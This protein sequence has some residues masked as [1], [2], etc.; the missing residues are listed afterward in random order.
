MIRFLAA[1]VVLALAAPAALADP[2][3]VDP[4]VA[5]GAS[6]TQLS[7]LAYPDPDVLPTAGGFRLFGT[8]A[9]IP[10]TQINADGSRGTRAPS[11]KTPKWAAAKPETW[12][13]DVWQT[14][15]PL[16]TY[17]MYFTAMDAA[18]HRHCLGVATAGAPQGPYTVT[19]RK[20]AT[21]CPR[22]SQH[23]AI[24]PTMVFDGTQRWMVFK[25]NVGNASDF[26]IQALP[27]NPSGVSRVKNATPAVLQGLPDERMENPAL[28]YH[29]GTWW[30]FL[31]RDDYT[32]CAYYTDAR[33]ATS[34]L[35]PYGAPKKITGAK[36]TGAAKA[37]G[38]CGAGGASLD[39][40]GASTR[41]TLHAF[42]D[43]AHACK[44]CRRYPWT[45]F[46][47]WNKNDKPFI[48]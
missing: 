11:L 24:D 44:T 19:N 16:P 22:D 12:A 42:K 48:D 46:L 2:P 25:D 29:D 37:G 15:G 23:E 21:W 33:P 39:Q 6:L 20:R 31:S 32:T 40:E 1:L 3:G 7:P 28:T 10:S 4:P 30:L 38:L 13:P 26:T 35:G 9:G 45:A 47:S 34:F 8:G 18:S 43:A 36:L 17:V 41:I 5:D 14:T 27:M